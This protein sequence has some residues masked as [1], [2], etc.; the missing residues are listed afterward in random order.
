MLEKDQALGSTISVPRFTAWF[1]IPE[2]KVWNSKKE[3]SY[4]QIQTPEGQY[5]L[6]KKI[7]LCGYCIVTD[8]PTEEGSVVGVAECVSSWALLRALIFLLATSCKEDFW[9]MNLMK[10]SSIQNSHWNRVSNQ[11]KVY[12]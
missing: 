10:I 6:T 8:C 5:R 1:S 9:V 12:S 2:L 4:D 3:I 11:K 7:G